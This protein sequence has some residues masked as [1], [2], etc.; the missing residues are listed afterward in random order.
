MSVLVVVEIGSVRSDEVV[1]LWMDLGKPYKLLGH[2]ISGTWAEEPKGLEALFPLVLVEERNEYLFQ[3]LPSPFKW[4]LMSAWEKSV[5]A[6][7][8]KV[9]QTKK[10]ERLRVEMRKG[11]D[12]SKWTRFSIIE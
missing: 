1:S 6:S 12:M 2:V 7:P 5:A 10:L 8:F 4:A 9:F 3:R 11:A